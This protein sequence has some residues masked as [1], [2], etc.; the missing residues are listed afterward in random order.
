MKKLIFILSILIPILVKAQKAI[1]GGSTSANTVVA[2]NN[3]QVMGTLY[4]GI[5]D[6]TFTPTTSGAMVTRPQDLITYIYQYSSSVGEQWWPLSGFQNLYFKNGMHNR[7]DSTGVLGGVVDSPISI[8]LR[9]LYPFQIDSAQAGSNEGFRVNFGNDAGWDLFTRDSITGYWTR[10]P[11]GSPGY[12]L[13]MLLTGGIGWGIS[14]NVT[15]VPSVQ[16]YNEKKIYITNNHVFEGNSIT[17]GYTLSSPSTQSYPALVVDTLGMTSSTNRAVTGSSVMDVINRQFTNDASTK[18]SNSYSVMIGINNYGQDTSGIK[19][20]AIREG[21]RTM[22]VN[23]FLDTVYAISNS[24]ITKTGSWNNLSAS[25]LVSKSLLKSLG[26]PMY[27][28]TSG[29][30]L[31]FTTYD[32]NFVIG[33]YGWKAG[34]SFGSVSISIDGVLQTNP[35]TNTTVWS[36]SNM[37]DQ[38]ASNINSYDVRMPITWVFTGL[39]IGAHTVIITL[40]QNTE[41]DFDYIG[42]MMLPINSAG[43]IVFH[44]AK[45]APIGYTNYGITGTVAGIDSINKNIDTVCNF[46][47]QKGFPV[48]TAHTNEFVNNSMYYT[49]GIHFLASGHIELANAFLT[50]VNRNTGGGSLPLSDTATSSSA[51]YESINDKI[52]LSHPLYIK[53]PTLTGLFDSTV[54]ANLDTAFIKSDSSGFGIGIRQGARYL[55]FFIDTNTYNIHTDGFNLAKYET[56]SGLASWPGTANITTLGT[57]GSGTWNGT[58]VSI[59]HGGTGVGTLP[60]GILKGAGTGAITAAVGADIPNITESQ[61][62]NLATDL[63]A[64][65]PLAGSSSI[66]TLGTIG[67]GIW[68]GTTVSPTYGGTGLSNP[69]GFLFFNGASN[70]TAM[71]TIPNT[72]IS[73]TLVTNIGTFNNSNSYANGASISGDSLYIGAVSATNPGILTTGNQN[74]P[75]TKTF[76]NA[77]NLTSSSTVGQVWTATGTGGQG[78]WANLP[79]GGTNYQTI[80]SNTSPLTQRPIL[81]FSNDFVVTDDAGNTSTDISISTTKISSGIYVPT[82]TAYSSTA[83][84]IIADSAVWCRVGN[85][86]TVSGSFS[87]SAA[88]APGLSVILYIS[89][90]IASQLNGGHA[91]WGVAVSTQAQ[92]FNSGAGALSNGEIGTYVSGHEAYVT[93]YSESTNTST[94]K[95]TYQYQ[96]Q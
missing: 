88:S 55:T 61:V 70:P 60:S 1:I 33:T 28:S 7:N 43:M 92:G 59:T 50:A 76:I 44:V 19:Q 90:P 38:F 65:S 74:I 62:T 6:T 84:G 22:I 14:G 91:L 72:D 56:Q 75:G 42:K 82:I 51:G 26:N 64:K 57:I 48:A 35:I 45:L 11:K 4:L 66:T 77:P 23:H 52:I 41:T 10:I 5:K 78:G 25:G 83:T 31:T 13:Q 12:T 37:S 81:N 53:N 39:G 68:N 17:Y 16:M 69:T 40:L 87:C 30:T 15:S 3:L 58:N 71:S 67:S 18:V 89:L 94:F 2:Q 63:A 86:V 32:N 21:I 85:I 95:Y 20:N 9:N 49:D 34:R 96:I 24:A 8:N 73:G 29:N 36:G 46:F 80:Q 54:T 47:R 79:S 93:W 27:S